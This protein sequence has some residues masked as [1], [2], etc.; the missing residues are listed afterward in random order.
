MLLD[1]GEYLAMEVEVGTCTIR[2]GFKSSRARA[3]RHYANRVF[4]N[5][6]HSLLKK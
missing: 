2:D 4:S 1:L 6:F 5:V 3:I